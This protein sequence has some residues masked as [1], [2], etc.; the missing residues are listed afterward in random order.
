ME[1]VRIYE[2]SVFSK[3]AIRR[4]IP[5]GCHLHDRCRENMKSHNIYINLTAL[6]YEDKEAVRG[7]GSGPCPIAGSGSRGVEPSDSIIRNS[8]LNLLVTEVEFRLVSKWFKVW[9]C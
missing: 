2:T 3:E 7:I 6:G 8:T 1:A 5:E 4:N 9:Y